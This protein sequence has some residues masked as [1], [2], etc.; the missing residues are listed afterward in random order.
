MVL[1]LAGFRLCRR[2]SLQPCPKRQHPCQ[3]LAVLGYACQ[4]RPPHEMV[5]DCYNTKY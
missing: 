3:P 2:T 4:I 5:S 1:M